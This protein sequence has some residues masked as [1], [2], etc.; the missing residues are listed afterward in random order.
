[1]EIKPRSG[2]VPRRG[3]PVFQRQPYTP[4]VTPCSTDFI[5]SGLHG[6]RL[7]EQGNTAANL[8]LKQRLTGPCAAITAA[9]RNIAKGSSMSMSSSMRMDDRRRFLWPGSLFL[10]L[11]TL[12]LA[13]CGSSPVI[14]KGVDTSKQGSVL[15]KAGEQYVRLVPNNG[16]MDNQHPAVVT[17]EEMRTALESLVIPERRFI[18]KK[19]NPVF[20]PGEIQVL[21]A[22]LAQGLALAQPNQD[23][24]FVTIGTHPGIFTKVRKANAGRV[25]FKDG[26][27][28]II[29]GMLHHEVRDTDP[30]TGAQI[31]RRLHPFV[32]GS[33]L[34]E[35]DLS[36]PIA[37]KE[38]QA[39][40][41]DPESGEEREDWVVL[42]IPTV[43][44]QAEGNTAKGPVSPG[45]PEEVARNKQEIQNLQED[46]AD[47]EEVLFELKKTLQELQQGGP[48]APF[49]ARLQSLKD[50][51]DSGLITSDE[52][53]G[54]RQELLDQL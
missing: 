34:S 9:L 35:T 39:F 23:I 38:G 12:G 48:D 28:N 21:S 30:Q 44:A 5:T 29:F 7:K 43:A 4:T 46:L 27:L 10:L 1:M 40:Y 15:W 6:R 33:R 31:D 53:R 17:V 25:F 49:K 50:L 8:T 54:K 19:L 2:S 14:K 13:A 20:S 36:T 3:F 22:A 11:L 37:L 45:L 18:R 42:D 32:V 26:R 51:H 52:Y 41:L 16:T 24:I 47:V